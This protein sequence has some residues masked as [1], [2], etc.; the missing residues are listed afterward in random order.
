MINADSNSGNTHSHTKNAQH[1]DHF[2][3][4]IKIIFRRHNFCYR[5]VHYNL[6]K[7][8]K[9]RNLKALKVHLLSKIISKIFEINDR[10]VNPPKDNFQIEFIGH[11]TMNS[12]YQSWNNI[13]IHPYI[14]PSILKNLDYAL[15]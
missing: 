14:R 6:K 4:R 15:S 12:E 7:H 2:V 13:D 9:V 3:F 11:I 10:H 5:F 1:K 8:T